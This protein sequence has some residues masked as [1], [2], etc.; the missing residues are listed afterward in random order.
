MTAEELK[1]LGAPKE[2]GIKVELI[3]SIRY[4]IAKIQD[5]QAKL[6]KQIEDEEH[7]IQSMRD[8]CPHLLKTYRPDPA[9]GSDHDY[10]CDICGKDGV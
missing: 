6:R 10:V 5:R 8:K 1:K 4:E 3:E 2:L 7:K 9:G